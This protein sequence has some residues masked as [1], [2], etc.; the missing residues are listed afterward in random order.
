VIAWVM[1]LWALAATTYAQPPIEHW[2]TDNGARV[3][4]SHAGELPMIDIR[5]VFDAGGARDG[6]NKG[7]AVLTNAM[8]A[9]GAGGLSAEAISERFENQGAQ[10]EYR[11][12]RD[13][14]WV[15]VRSLSE[16]ANLKQALE[17]LALVLAKPDFPESAFERQ[18]SRLLV[19][20]AQKR[21]SPSDV[22]D[23]AFYQAAYGDHP[24]ASDPNGTP[25]TLKALKEQDLSQFHRRY[26]VA[27]NAVVA[28]IG[29]L[30][31]AEAHTVGNAVVARLSQGEAPAPLP[32]VKPPSGPITRH[33]A[34]SSTQTHI[35]IGQIGIRR[36]DPD[37]FPLY[38]AN[39][40][41]GGSGL[42]SRLADEVREKRGLSYSVSSRF[43]PMRVRGPFI[44]GLETKNAQAREA[45]E[46]TTSSLR[47]FIEHG[48]TERELSASILNLTGG[49]P[50]LI[51]SNAEMVE[52]LA[53]IGSYGLPLD[54]LHTFVSKI[55]GVT[56]ER[57]VEALHRRMTPNRLVTVTVGGKAPQAAPTAL[58][59]EKSL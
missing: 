50:L 31:N 44:V 13:M 39:H 38:V 59:R 57:I 58:K 32:G 9:E 35:R 7:L 41:L 55:K 45:L 10:F 37:Y 18:R 16:Q 28:M 40:V 14:A 1:G 26:Y 8:L 25:E 52:Y 30:S 2:Q 19:A 11:A 54:F 29:D 17:T 15:S 49:F 20:L 12:L 3:Y 5:V 53:M 46:V 23:E 24:Y 47:A 56:R 6:V 43:S 21:Q 34:H 22:V 4:F 48:P 51:D 36:D 27:G 42:V 33:L